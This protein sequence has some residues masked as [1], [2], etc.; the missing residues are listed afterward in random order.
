MKQQF[1]VTQRYAVLEETEKTWQILNKP[2][3]KHVVFFRKYKQKQFFFCG[4]KILM[5]GVL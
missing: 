4:Y 3:F 5:E 1:A 2:T